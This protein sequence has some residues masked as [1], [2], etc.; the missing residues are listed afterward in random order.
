MGLGISVGS[1][2]KA[3]PYRKHVWY[4]GDNGLIPESC[5]LEALASPSRAQS[6]RGG[7]LPKGTSWTLALYTDADIPDFSNHFILNAGSVGGFAIGYGNGNQNGFRTPDG[8]WQDSGLFTSDPKL[9]FM[10]SD[11]STVKTYRGLEEVGLPTP[12]FDVAANGNWKSCLGSSLWEWTNEI[13]VALYD[14]VLSYAEQQVLCISMIR[15]ELILETQ[16]D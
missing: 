8:V 5:V 12:A 13:R 6:Y 9:Y 15:P 11:G 10:V 3:E 14:K 1:T 16:G 4:T 7:N 2:K